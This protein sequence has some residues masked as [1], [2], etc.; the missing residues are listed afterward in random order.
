MGED[1]A[2]KFKIADATFNKYFLFL[3]EY[4]LARQSSLLS[5]NQVKLKM[6]SELDVARW[7]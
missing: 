6:P 3:K 7:W 4:G 2:K 5:S 1:N